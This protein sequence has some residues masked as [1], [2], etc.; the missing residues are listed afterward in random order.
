MGKLKSGRYQHKSVVKDARNNEIKC[1]VITYLDAVC[2]FLLPSTYVLCKFDRA[3]LSQSRLRATLKA[4]LTIA[5]LCSY[6]LMFY[7]VLCN[8]DTN[9]LIMF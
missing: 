4:T 2:M 5:F 8:F 7:Y 3:T 9:V 1:R 6:G